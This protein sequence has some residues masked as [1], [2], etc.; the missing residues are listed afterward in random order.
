MSVD[1]GHLDIVKA[2]EESKGF[3]KNRSLGVIIY[4]KPVGWMGSL[5]REGR[6]G[7][8]GEYGEVL[9]FLRPAGPWI[10]VIGSLL[11]L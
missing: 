11:T 4:T 2:Q 3:E 6:E 7:R 1:K 5:G 8:G 10:L 9:R